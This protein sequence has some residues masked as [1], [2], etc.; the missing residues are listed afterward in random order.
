MADPLTITVPGVLRGKGRPRFGRGRVH[1]DSKTEAAENGLVAHALAQIGTPRLE[2]PLV[3]TIEIA[4]EVPASWSKRK[5]ADALAHLLR[6]MGRPDLDN[7][8]KLVADALN[9]IAWR[10]DAQLV[11]LEV[12]RRYGEVAQTR[13]EITTA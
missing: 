11:G 7:Q 2:G 6:P 12:R 4:V 10:D 13:I 9:G 1:T 5:R 8:V 3:L